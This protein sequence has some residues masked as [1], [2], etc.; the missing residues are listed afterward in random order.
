MLSTAIDYGAGLRIA[1]SDDPRRRRRWVSFS[2]VSNLSILGTFKYAGFFAE[3]LR[4]LAAVAGLSLSDF[5]LD[6]VLPVGISFYTFQTMSYSLDLYRRKIPVEHNLLRFATYVAF[7]PQLVAGPIVRAAHF[8]PQ[9][10]S[11]HRFSWTRMYSGLGLILLGYF[12]KV[13]VADSL[14]TVIDLIFAY[15][16][17]YTSLNLI[18]APVLY[19]F[20][21]YCD[22]WSQICHTSDQSVH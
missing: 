11:D 5:A 2:I 7:F 13:V 4:D 17:S 16:E 14:A 3:S 12:K 21:I 22:F 19:A 9:L 15:P 18:I 1:Q 10:Q 8:L 20:Q 6:V